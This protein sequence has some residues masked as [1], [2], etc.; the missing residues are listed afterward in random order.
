MVNKHGIGDMQ[1]MQ[2]SFDSI[3]PERPGT[4]KRKHRDLGPRRLQTLPDSRQIDPGMGTRPEQKGD[5][6]GAGIRTGRLISRGEHLK[7][8][9]STATMLHRIR[10]CDEAVGDNTATAPMHHQAKNTSVTIRTTVP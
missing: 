10:Q 8:H 4:E 1:P 9:R 7:L 5:Q 2:N 3:P 6:P